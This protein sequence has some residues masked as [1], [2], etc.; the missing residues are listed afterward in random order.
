MA[1]AVCIFT[2]GI[3]FFILFLLLYVK[4]T[5]YTRKLVEFLFVS[6]LGLTAVSGITQT[7]FHILKKSNVTI[8]SETP[9]INIFFIIHHGH[10]LSIFWVIFSFFVFFKRW[11]KLKRACIV[12][13]LVISPVIPVFFLNALHYT[14]W[15]SGRGSLKS[16]LN[17][18]KPCNRQ[19]ADVYIFIFDEWSYRRT[20]VDKQLIDSFTNLNIFKKQALVF[21][22][23]YS[24]GPNT[25]SS[26]P[27]FLF[28]TNLLFS[29]NN[30]IPGFNGN[31]HTPL[32]K[33]KTIFYYPR[34][35]GYSTCITGAYIP[36][37][38]LLG[39]SVDFSSSISVAKRF[40]SSFYNVAGY[41]MFSAATIVFPQLMSGLTKRIKE[42]YFNK[43]Q[44]KR[45]SIEDEFFRAVVKK[46]NNP[47]FAVYHYMLPH[48]PYIF[49]TGGAKPLFAIYRE[50]PDNYIENLAYLDQK[51]GWIMTMLKNNNKFDKSLVIFMSDHSWRKDP[52]NVD[53]NGY[54]EKCHVP[55]F[56]KFPFQ[57]NQVE[58]DSK[59]ST[60][61]LGTFI[62]ECLDSGLKQMKAKTILNN[63][64]FFKPPGAKL[65]G[66]SF[67]NA[68]KKQ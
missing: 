49:K 56:V 10:I 16:F 30:G 38:T 39:N 35:L 33:F 54:L 46:N 15:Q 55:L 12:F 8:T 61:M 13:C 28:Q 22:N 42:Y 19:L 18:Q 24:P 66:N 27:G 47:V 36:Y 25:F 60:S 40:G 68:N 34:L 14:N 50:T 57:E 11:Q 48:F 5:A 1:L 43:F 21:H 6:A 20:F 59:F 58:I 3:I 2:A 4:G 32:N 52:L 23:A 63:K 64:S 51:I 29:V 44:L 31:N 62:N 9:L 17:E 26:I 37:G 67:G 7:I 41:H 53:K 45:I 65:N